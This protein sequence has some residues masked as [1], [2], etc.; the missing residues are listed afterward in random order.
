[1]SSRRTVGVALAVLAVAVA[2]VLAVQYLPATLTTA[3]GIHDDARVVV[4]DDGERAGTVTVSVADT[5]RDRYVGLSNASSLPEGHGM[6]FVYPAEAER[7][8]VMREMDFALDIVF[9]G[10]DGRITAIHQASPPPAGTD[11]DDLTR[12]TGEAKWVLEVPLN[13]TDER[14][15][16]VGDRVRVN[17]TTSTAASPSL[18]LD[19]N[20]NAG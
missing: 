16:T 19:G 2:V 8:F 12:Y 1:M 11:E 5:P 18:L 4:V 3:G 13:W 14:G 9:V 7:A 10:A 15:V 17:Y 6:L 20:F